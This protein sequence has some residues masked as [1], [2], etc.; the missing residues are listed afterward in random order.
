MSTIAPN[1][2]QIFRINSSGVILYAKGVLLPQ[3]VTTNLFSIHPFFEIIPELSMRKKAYKFPLVHF[4]KNSE[5]IVCNVSIMIKSTN[6]TIKL[7]D[8]TSVYFVL[9]KKEQLKNENFLNN[10]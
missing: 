6:I 10:N 4:Q 1:N 3:K 7:T 8:M 9:Q 5:E 2:V